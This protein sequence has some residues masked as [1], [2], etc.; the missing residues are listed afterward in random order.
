MNANGFF[1]DVISGQKQGPGR[2]L[3]P[4]LSACVPLYRSATALHGLMFDLGWRKTQ[5][6]SVPVVSI[7]NLTTGGTGKTP[8]VSWM[9]NRLQAEGLKPAILSRGYR[10]LDEGGNDEKRLLDAMCPGVPHIQ[11]GDRV[12]GAGQAVIESGCHALVLD[13][14]FQH[15]RLYR[16]LD[17]V[18]IDA[19][20]PWGYGHLLPRGL[21]REPRSALGRADVVIMT[22]A[23]LV[24]DST[25]QRLQDDIRR[26][27]PAPIC[28]SRFKPTGW[29]SDSG[30]RASLDSLSG[31]RLAV[32]CGIGNP[33][34]FLRTLAACGTAPPGEQWQQVFP[35]H[36][37]Y[38]TTDVSRL[39]D[40]S[41]ALGAEC[42]VTTRKDLVKVAQLTG[43]RRPIRALDIELEIDDPEP[44]IDRLHA[45]TGP[46]R[47][48]R[49]A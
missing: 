1:L 47:R 3:R 18:L 24:D 41:D 16:D 37:H 4:W 34:G 44:L 21:L 25:R 48:R 13:D 7:G 6:A 45:V 33:E 20:N 5:H 27:T 19:V 32:F 43:G 38:T 23:D 36:H 39:Y 40:W 49:A 15:R 46:E 31:Q 8:T 12:A 10:S 29:I 9:V 14:G 2:L 26:W 30:E 11:N 42:L 35:D 28:V 22:R 17:V